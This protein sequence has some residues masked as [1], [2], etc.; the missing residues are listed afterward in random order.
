MHGLTNFKFRKYEGVLK[1]A[2]AACKSSPNNVMKMGTSWRAYKI[3][4]NIMER[5]IK[6]RNV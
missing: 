1:F 2:A 3:Q 4:P 6:L 5:E